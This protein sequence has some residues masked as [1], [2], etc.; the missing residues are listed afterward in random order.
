VKD[1]II[2]NASAVMASSFTSPE[3]EASPFVGA[4]KAVC[5]KHSALL[6][7]LVRSPSSL[8][9]L[10]TQLTSFRPAGDCLR[11]LYFFAGVET[12]G[13]FKS[14]F[15]AVCKERNWT[16]RIDEVD[17][18]KGSADGLLDHEAQAHWRASIKDYHC[19]VFTPPCNTHTRAVWANS[20][21]P[22]P[23]RSADFPLGF[24]WLTQENR[25]KADNANAVADFAL[26]GA[27]HVHSLRLQGYCI[28]GFLEH[29]EDLGRVAGGFP[30]D[31]PASLWRTDD[32]LALRAAGW[33]TT[34]MR[35][36][37]KGAP[38]LKP[39]RLMAPGAPECYEALGPCNWPSFDEHGWY[40][41]PVTF[42]DHD[43]TVSLIR[44]PGDTGPFRTNA[45]SAYPSEMCSEMVKG[46]LCDL[47]K[48]ANRVTPSVG[49][50]LATGEVE[51]FDAPMVK[52]V[53]TE[54]QEEHLQDTWTPLG[55]GPDPV[56]DALHVVPI[57]VRHVEGVDFV[58]AGWWGSGCPIRI[59]KGPHRE[60]RFLQD[61]A[62]LCSPGRWRPENRVLPPQGE[63]ITAMLVSWVDGWL[64]KHCNSLVE[65]GTAYLS[66]QLSANPLAEDIGSLRLELETF[67]ELHGCSKAPMTPR[68]GQVIEFGLLYAL[69]KYLED[70]DF[71]SMKEFCTGVRVGVGV[72][73]HRTPA[74][75][76]EKK[77]WPLD[78]F[79]TL[80]VSRLNA[81]YPSAVKEVAHLKD[82]L[83]KQVEMGWL[84]EISYK[85]A[86]ER[87]GEICVSSMAVIE[88]K[89]GK[90]RTLL[91]A[92]NRVQVNNRIKVRDLEMLPTA[93]DVQAAVTADISLLQPVTGLSA[94]VEHAHRRSP[95][96]EQDWGLLGCSVEPMPDDFRELDGWR[97]LL[98]CVGTYGV[99]SASWQFARFA[100]MMQ[101]CG[102]YICKI[103]WLFRFADDF[104]LIT[105][106]RDGAA[107]FWPIVL[108][109]VL[110][111]IMGFPLKWAKTKGGATSEFVG[112]L[113]TWY[114]LKGGLSQRRADWLAQWAS[115]TASSG[116]AEAREVKGALGRFSFS[117]A[118]LRH[119]LPFL[120]PIYAWASILHDD[121]LWP[122]PPA[123]IVILNWLSE[124]IK[125][126][127]MV[128]L[129]V[130]P[131]KRSEFVFKADAKA[132]GTDVSVGGFALGPGMSTMNAKWFA[133]DLTP[134]NAEWAF[135]KEGQAFRTISS[136]ELFAS[137][138]CV[139]LFGGFARGPLNLSITCITDNQ[140]N[141]ALISK[142]MTTKF[143]LFLIL[144]E[145]VEQLEKQGVILEL[146]WQRRELN[147]DAD[148]L[149]NK[150]FSNFNPELRMCPNLSDLPWIILPRLFED[151]ACLFAHIADV[152]AA[153]K[154]KKVLKG[155]GPSCLKPKRFKK[156][157]KAGLR[158]THPW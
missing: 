147:Q 10:S 117:A 150:H 29:P 145:L 128:D 108:F 34:G 119:L 27:W 123:I 39:T 17:F 78:D 124:K 143:P 11:V 139:M 111:A 60:G 98:N 89:P 23:I 112:Y 51:C 126:L 76:P 53:E 96:S 94:D 87:F 84:L 137:L 151:A 28:T 144:I 59:H 146:I 50:M 88:E 113:F 131:T 136:L 15:M 4:S 120:G 91:D 90:H 22:T 1:F 155:K 152:R 86:V 26:Q 38:T 61:G 20:N 45:T 127:P 81:N 130:K 115:R 105:T 122:L 62:G 31:V 44:K 74:V 116:C 109:M 56:E 68:K 18:L 142:N 65:L 42:C 129:V 72:E 2:A 132:E 47:D 57:K 134:E 21:G 135:I 95:I 93:C 7:R 79:G 6:P 106:G 5:D 103:R 48:V 25:Q 36:C 82:E 66:G 54:F 153:V 100:S 158:V 70:P 114:D 92:S 12:K 33:W 14:H 64:E 30:R 37:D 24:P 99:A 121:A 104:L 73:L 156:A 63:A 141:D 149:T 52:V 32:A 110:C 101:R 67:L 102:Y 3:Q 49:E 148:D 55:P 19:V 75:W 13:D 157:K 46:M 16:L 58:R 71:E 138:L 35:Q 85:D 8:P 133:Y 40:L 125:L 83:A 69:A 41:G 80:P 154:A 140:G 9:V 107:D 77:S 43:H 97:L 118:L